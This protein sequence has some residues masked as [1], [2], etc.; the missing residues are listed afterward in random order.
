MIETDFLRYVWSCG[1]LTFPILGWNVVF[2][3]FL[4][5]PLATNEFWRDIP[6][7]VS[8]GEHGLR[9]RS[10]AKRSGY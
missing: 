8:L 1:V 3:R 9:I 7:F 5:P 6:R 10:N 2:F 4:P